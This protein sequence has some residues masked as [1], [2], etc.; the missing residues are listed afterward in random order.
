[1]EY[2]AGICTR[3]KPSFTT[4][5][6]QEWQK[7]AK[8]YT[9]ECIKIPFKSSYGNS[10]HQ[11]IAVIFLVARPGIFP[12]HEC[13]MTLPNLCVID[14]CYAETK[15]ILFNCLKK[16][17]Q[18]IASF[19][20]KKES[21]RGP[22]FLQQKLDDPSKAI[23]EFL[24]EGAVNMTSNREVLKTDKFKLRWEEIIGVWLHV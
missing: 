6:N 22:C 2:L 5:I 23:V 17:F 3:K 14:L 20:T 9:L 18:W 4:I 24:E 13:L 16:L 15:A 1:M 21:F 19:R 10:D 12:F 8:T 7:F 11:W